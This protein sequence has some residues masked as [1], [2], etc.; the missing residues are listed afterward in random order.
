MRQKN[1]LQQAYGRFR[2]TFIATIVFS[3]FTNLLMFVGPLY[4]LQIYDRV[5]SSRNENTLI[6]ITVI[7]IALLLSYGLLEFT[8]SKLLVRAGV[9]FDDVLANPVFNR[10]VRQQTANPG[11]GAQIA[12]TDIDKVREFMTGQG[13]LAFFDAP[14]VPLF[15]ALCFAFHPWLGAVATI[16]ALIIF[17][18]A[19]ANEFAT[20]GALQEAGKASQGANHFVTTT[21]QNAEVIRALGME[22]QL[23]KRWIDQHDAMLQHQAKAS[24]RAGIILASSKFV[25]MT[26]QVGILGVGAYLA[27]QQLI[28]PGIMIA[29]S[30][31]MGRALAPVEQ[32][33]GQWKQFVAARQA[34]K[35]LT[36]LFNTLGDEEERIELPAP[37]GIISVE[38]L[39]AVAPGTRET[40]LKNV[41]FQIS[42]GETLAIIGPSGSGKSTLVRH[43]VGAYTPA[44]GAVRLDGT[45]LQHW[46][47]EQ[48][49]KHMGY[50]PQDVKL[51]RGS[52][53]ENIS[54]FSDMPKDQDI[55]A[56]ATLSGAH[57]MIQK[58]SQ[59]YETDVGDG[60]TALSGGQRQRV[61]LARAVYGNPS[62]IV[63]DEPNS[64]LDSLGEQAL[65]SCLQELKKRGKT[66]ILVTHKTNLLALSDKTLMLVGGTVEKF[67]PTREM[68]QGAAKSAGAAAQQMAAAG[69]QQPTV[70]SMPQPVAPPAAE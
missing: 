26:L 48:V 33:V 28:S 29:A 67:G 24:G 7:S 4:M 8:R 34:H 42:P 43:L 21:M 69:G 35:R 16:G 53:A 59:G 58:L 13:I 32:A 15:L 54:R 51:F 37:K 23:T 25:R 61:G 12:L 65:A 38:Q 3:F 49:G 41:S 22:K 55:V 6:M 64:N 5:L 66:I 50:L 44:S 18:L 11:S 30:I 60:G 47:P 52:V 57:D 10:V 63:L 31:V 70:V 20:R 36:Q 68:F 45:E 62:L 19:I 17:S 27:M 1:S 40:L 9:Q 39:F 14:W 2:A 56:A 46:D